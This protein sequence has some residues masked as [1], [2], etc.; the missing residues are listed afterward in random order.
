MFLKRKAEIKILFNPKDSIQSERGSFDRGK[1]I[2]FVNERD[3]VGRLLPITS[4]KSHRPMLSNHNTQ[5]NPLVMEHQRGIFEN[6]NHKRS[7]S[8]NQ[9]CLNLKDL[10]LKVVSKDKLKP[11]KCIFF[12]NPKHAKTELENKYEKQIDEKLDSVRSTNA[13]SVYKRVPEYSFSK[14][15]KKT[16]FQEGIEK[17]RNKDFDFL[18]V[19]K[20]QNLLQRRGS[21]LPDYSR[22]LKASHLNE[23]KPSL[24]HGYL[25]KVLNSQDKEN[26][27]RNLNRKSSFDSDCCL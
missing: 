9:K 23:V 7:V 19:S 3:G 25:M 20:A 24:S 13:Q 10:L 26:L 16:I 2:A 11:K 22:M 4:F 15:V 27:N 1:F 12:T 14:S 6:Q 21:Y 18:E 5:E 8:H 17:Y